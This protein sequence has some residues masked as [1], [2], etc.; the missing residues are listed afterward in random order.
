MPEI[1]TLGKNEI[2][3]KQDKINFKNMCVHV[4]GL[5]EKL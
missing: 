1:K 3:F 5:A 4:C 2:G